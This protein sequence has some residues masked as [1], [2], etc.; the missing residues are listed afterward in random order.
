MTI[1]PY[2]GAASWGTDS[3]QSSSGTFTDQKPGAMLGILHALC[4]LGICRWYP[5]V[6]ELEAPKFTG[7]RQGPPPRNVVGSASPPFWLL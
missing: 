5:G 6:R 1:H 7:H 2:L 4:F 3:Q